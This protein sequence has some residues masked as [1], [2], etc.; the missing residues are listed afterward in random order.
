MTDQTQAPP[1]PD[2]AALQ[3]EVERLRTHSAE[4]LADLKAERQ[5]RKTAEEAL[6]AASGQDGGWKA[7]FHK[8]HVLEPL[9]RELSAAAAVPAEYLQTICTKHGLLTWED[10]AE[11]LSCPVWKQPDGKPADLSNG[12][13]EYLSSI[14]KANP[15]AFED[16]GKTLRASGISGM[17]MGPSQTGARSTPP[18]EATAQQYGL[19]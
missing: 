19:R 4:L 18:Q 1:A 10:D 9:E 15:D 11:G 6:Q 5:A 8:S 12:L 14:Y 7:R 16:L 3:A 2:A 13:H 17:G